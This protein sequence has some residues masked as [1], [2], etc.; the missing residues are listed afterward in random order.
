MAS[1]VRL[2]MLVLLLASLASSVAGQPPGRQDPP[3][4]APTDDMSPMQVHQLFDAMLV[5]QAQDALSLSEQQY[6][7][8]VSRVKVLQDTRRRSQQMRLRM[9]NELQRITSP[10]AKPA[11]D[12]EIK[13]RLDA[14]HETEAR[15]AADVRRAYDGIDEVLNPLQ[16]ARFRVLEEQIE[17]R[18][19]E[20]VGR[21]RQN[22]RQPNNQRPPLR[23]PPGR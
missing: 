7:Q 2:C 14:L 23:R 9:I 21:A 12:A 3:P 8:F 16:Q 5:M 11:G 1:P 4:G 6:A 15:S 22:Q 10:R 18:K 19:L 13:R 17:R 20:L